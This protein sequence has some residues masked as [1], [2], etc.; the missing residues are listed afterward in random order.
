[1]RLYFFPLPF[2]TVGSKQK[3]GAKKIFIIF[4]KTFWSNGFL[5]TNE[6]AFC[7]ALMRYYMRCYSTYFARNATRK[8]RTQEIKFCRLAVRCA[9]HARII[10]HSS[11]VKV[12]S[13]KLISQRHKGCFISF[14]PIFSF[15]SIF[16]IFNSEEILN[17]WICKVSSKLSI[18]KLSF[19]LHQF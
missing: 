12:F 15:F 6:Y 7:S 4:D 19:N 9:S 16:G 11:A 3:S 14:N 17:I 10:V 8:I 18:K 5:I 1:M 2:P 13:S